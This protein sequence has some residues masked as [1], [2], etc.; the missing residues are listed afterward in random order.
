MLLSNNFN[1]VFEISI[2]Y[3][4][5]NKKR[6]PVCVVLGVGRQNYVIIMVNVSININSPCFP[7]L[8]SS[9]NQLNSYKT[10]LTLNYNQPDEVV[11]E[12]TGC[13]MLLYGLLCLL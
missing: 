4:S 8:H 13:G 3:V 10:R 9:I 1:C 11:N 7:I 2:Q 5:G 12:T 6:H